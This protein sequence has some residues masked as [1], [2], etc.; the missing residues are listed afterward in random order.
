[1]TNLVNTESQDK[2]QMFAGDFPRA[3]V[4]I[5]IILGSG[6][7][8]AGTVLGKVI[9]GAATSAAKTDGNTGDG[10]LTLDETTPI[11]AKAKPGIYKVRVIRAAIAAIGETSPAMKGIAQLSDPDGNVLSV[12]DLPTTPGVTIADQVK[13]AIIEGSTPF[14]LGDGFDITIA[15]GSNNY[16][17]YDDDNIDGS[18]VAKLILAEDIDAT[19]ATVY[20][21]A[22]KSGQFNEAALTGLDAAAKVDF[23]G[24]PI[25]FGSVV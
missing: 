21:T 4:A 16:K 1:M 13:F 12:F 18:E 15:A 20:T 14:A 24:T 8:A 19:S 2:I 9:K 22:Y 3:I 11:L 5:V 10:T 6:I 23:E 7:L 17:P 25:F